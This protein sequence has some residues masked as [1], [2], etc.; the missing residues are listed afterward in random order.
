MGGFIHEGLVS[1]QEVHGDYFPLTEDTVT[2][3]ESAVTA[4]TYPSVLLPADFGV[5]VQDGFTIGGEPIRVMTD[6]E[7]RRNRRP[8]SQGGGTY[9]TQLTGTPAQTQALLRL[10]QSR[11]ATAAAAIRW[12]AFLYPVQTAAWTLEVAYRATAKAL[13]GD[14]DVVRLPNRM[15]RP[16]MLYC[17]ARSCEFNGDTKGAAERW[18]L[19]NRA[20]NEVESIPPS[21]EQQ[22]V[23]LLVPPLDA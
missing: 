7:W 1:L 11:Q 22:N 14:T 21:L 20:L 19:Y 15:L 8:D 10:V 3:Q 2:A 5:A 16:L 12:A 23:M 18:A 13:S 6:G 17:N 9:L 4:G